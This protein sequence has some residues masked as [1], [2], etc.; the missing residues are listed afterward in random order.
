MHSTA[1]ILR[2]PKGIDF[3][4]SAALSRLYRLSLFSYPPSSHPRFSFFSRLLLL[5]PP[6]LLSLTH[7]HT[8]N[9]VFM[10]LLSS[11]LFV[12]HF[13]RSSAPLSPS[14]SLVMPACFIALYSVSKP[15]ASLCSSIRPHTIRSQFH[16]FSAVAPHS[17]FS[18]PS[19]FPSLSCVYTLHLSNHSIVSSQSF[20]AVCL[21]LSSSISYILP[22][23]SVCASAANV[24]SLPPLLRLSLC[25]G[26]VLGPAAWLTN[27]LSLQRRH[28]T[29][30]RPLYLTSRSYL[31][32]AI[33]AECC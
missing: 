9:N 29:I 25:M 3:C 12:L 4:R 24:L 14:G 17:F 23:L 15:P 31:I 32:A 33:L 30:S 22:L 8:H 13:V 6:F 2:P 27:G 16:L 19:S 11:S 20:L 28:I 18:P 10:I 26:P 7:T 5:F 21:S 1:P